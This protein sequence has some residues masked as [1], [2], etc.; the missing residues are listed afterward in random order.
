MR[1]GFIGCVESSYRILEALVGSASSNIEVVAVVTR[2]TS[3]VNSDFVDLAPFCEEH[4][5]PYHYEESGK[6]NASLQFFKN[7]QLDI[8]YCFGWSYLLNK[9]M[10]NVAPLGAIGFHPAPLP[11]GRGRHPIIWSIALG[12]KS[13]AVTF[14]RLDEGAD[15]GPIISQTP[16]DISEKDSAETLYNKILEIATVQVIGFTEALA[17]GNA[18]SIPQDEL[19][20]TYWR[21]RSRADG[22]IDW[23]MNAG[24][25]H[26]LIRALSAPYPGAEF[27]YLGKPISVWKSEISDSDYPRHFESGRVLKIDSSKYLIKCGGT[28]A[29]WL[30]DIELPETVTAGD[31]L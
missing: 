28:S 18:K 20:S 19:H 15:T 30:I 13:T 8:I 26:N 6:R 4:G 7:Y 27:M 23:R 29:I 11:I 16:V 2:A 31:Y 14:F 5:I 22:M 21:K 24:D 17:N 9:E 1:I 12:L 25:I 10:L 3:N